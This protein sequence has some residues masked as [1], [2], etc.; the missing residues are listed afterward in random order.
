MLN[1]TRK[2]TDSCYLHV[3]HQFITN[4]LRMMEKT[5][6]QKILL[7]KSLSHAAVS[8]VSRGL[9]SEGPGQ[10]GKY[11]QSYVCGPGHT[12]LIGDTWSTRYI[13]ISIP[14]IGNTIG[15]LIDIGA[16]KWGN[17]REAIVSVHQVDSLLWTL[18][19]NTDFCIFAEHK[20]R[21]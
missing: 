16:A 13:F 18:S 10:L 5:I 6:L 17:D 11:S 2:I 7:N 1:S 14:C 19:L 3:W 9:S 8:L 20:E 15:D 12:P 21:F 4:C